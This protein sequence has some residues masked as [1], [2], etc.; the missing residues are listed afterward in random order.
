MN[1]DDKYI[2]NTQCAD[3]ELTGVPNFI[4]SDDRGTNLIHS[5]QIES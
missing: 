1:Q 5:K 2:Y 3:R 4:D